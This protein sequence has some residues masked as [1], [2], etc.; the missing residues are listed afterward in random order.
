MTDPSRPTLTVS[1]VAEGPIPPT[2][3]SATWPNVL[4]TR[5]PELAARL[6]PGAWAQRI[7]ADERQLVTLISSPA[8]TG[9]RPHWHRDF[10]EWW[11]VMAGRLTWELT[12]GTRLEAGTGDI[13]WVPRGTVHHIKTLG[14]E[15]SLR[16]AVAM[17]PA[18]HYFSPCEQCGFT[19]DGPREWRA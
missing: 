11:V 7:I 8:G 4:L 6:G 2:A 3:A 5:V 12:G 10:D 14:V 19:D 16:L 15:R 1:H 9:N 17:P 13:V 18:V